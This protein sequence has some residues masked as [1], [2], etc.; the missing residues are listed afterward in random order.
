MIC[1]SFHLTDPGNDLPFVQCLKLLKKLMKD[2]LQ[3]GVEDPDF[4]SS[5]WLLYIETDLEL[6]SNLHAMNKTGKKNLY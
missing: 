5:V 2:W 1:I 4:S 3:V 6:N